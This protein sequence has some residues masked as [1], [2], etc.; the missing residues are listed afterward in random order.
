MGEFSHII[1][2]M[3]W[4]FS[5]LE[6]FDQCPYGW[7]SSYIYDEPERGIFFS[8]F[9]SCVHSVSAQ[10]LSGEMGY[11]LLRPRYI[12]EFFENCNGYYPSQKIRSERFQDGLSYFS[13][14]FSTLF[15]L[16]AREVLDVERHFEMALGDIPFNGI[17]DLVSGDGGLVVTD[18]KSSNIKPPS[19]RKKPTQYDIER[20]QKS[21]QLYVYAQAIKELYG[22]YPDRLEFNCYRTPQIISIPFNQKDM[23][24]T[25]RWANDKARE[26][27]KCDDF[28]PNVDF[29]YCKN[30]CDLEECPYRELL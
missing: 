23:D 13:S 1:D 5:R 3:T 19:G 8:E 11:E 16:S 10:Y 22:Q 24:A 25:I 7:V 12:S 14:P 28:V 4:S 6:S 2:D 17:I 15:D 20:E 29:F 18:H 30:L 26:I 9:G 27:S 21:R